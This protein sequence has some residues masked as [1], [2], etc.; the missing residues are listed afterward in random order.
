MLGGKK[1]SKSP[2]SGEVQYEVVDVPDVQRPL[3]SGSFD[4]VPMASAVVPMATAYQA[5]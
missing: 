2:H 4:N 1:K 5:Y 3:A